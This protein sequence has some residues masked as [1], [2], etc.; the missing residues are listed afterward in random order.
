MTVTVEPDRDG[1]LLEDWTLLTFSLLASEDA[2]LLMDACAD[3]QGADREDMDF[4]VAMANGV[5]SLLDGDLAA[6][7]VVHGTVVTVSPSAILGYKHRAQDDEKA[8]VGFPTYNER[9]C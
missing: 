6:Q 1:Y 4:T 7:G 2:Q 5:R 3:I 9:I 8:R